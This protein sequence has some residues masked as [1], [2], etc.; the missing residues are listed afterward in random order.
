MPSL[1][2]CPLKWK[3]PVVWSSYSKFDKEF[4]QEEPSS[5]QV[6]VSL[7]Y[8][9]PEL[10]LHIQAPAH[11]QVWGLSALTSPEGLWALLSSCA[12]AEQITW[13]ISASRRAS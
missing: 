1:K 10:R 5:A 8:P 6:G 9:N 13:I 3:P 11:E 7:M 2:P 12:A 4:L